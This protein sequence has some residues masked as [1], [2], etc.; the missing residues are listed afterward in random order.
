[1]GR[2]ILLYDPYKNH[3]A[4]Q[5]KQVREFVTSEKRL[6]RV[7]KTQDQAAAILSVDTNLVYVVVKDVLRERRENQKQHEGAILKDIKKGLSRDTISAKH[8]VS[9]WFVDSLFKRVHSADKE[10][11]FSYEKCGNAFFY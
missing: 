10:N 6:P 5:I 11:L 4:E 7:K 1:M 2:R 3:T 8:R 9:K